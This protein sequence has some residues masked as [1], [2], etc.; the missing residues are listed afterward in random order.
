LC[1]N[2]SARTLQGSPLDVKSEVG[3]CTG[4][5]DEVGGEI[6]PAEA[7]IMPGRGCCK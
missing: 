6:L 3:V 7:T 4:W 2:T 5:L 1:A